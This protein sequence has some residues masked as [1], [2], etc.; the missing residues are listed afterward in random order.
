[1]SDLYPVIN[2]NQDCLTSEEK[3]I[4]SCA[5]VTTDK[6]SVRNNSSS[7]LN[8]NDIFNSASIYRL[9]PLLY[10]HLQGIEGCSRVVAVNVDAHAPIVQR[11]DMA[12]IGDAN[13]VVAA[14]Y[15]RLE[16]TS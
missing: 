15:T 10:K 1:M 12:I 8:W 14:L 13:A 3:L 5:R 9:Q 11:A 16:R 7:N 4:F 2:S 6:A